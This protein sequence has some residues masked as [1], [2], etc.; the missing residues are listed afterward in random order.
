MRRTVTTLAALVLLV[1]LALTGLSARENVTGK[2]TI[3]PARDQRRVNLVLL[4]SD[5]RNSHGHSIDSDE[6]DPGVLGLL[7]ALSASAQ[8][9]VDFTLAHEAGD[10]ACSGTAGNGRGSGTFVFAPSERFLEKMRARGYDLTLK[11]TL[12]AAM[13]DL[14]VGFVDEV[15]AAGYRGLPYEKL[16]VFRAIGIDGTYIRSTQGA[17]PGKG[18]SADD[19]IPLRSLGVTGR[20][21]DEMRAAGFDVRDSQEAIRLRAV[22][23]DPAFA[24]DIGR[25]LSAPLH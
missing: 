14:T 2:W 11:Q 19:L 5:G 7:P 3:E 23:V 6:L 17:F 4:T 25:R 22:G 8:R 20:F 1:Q 16:I 12:Q 18:V 9:H 13:L 24:R 10:F 15:I 21:V